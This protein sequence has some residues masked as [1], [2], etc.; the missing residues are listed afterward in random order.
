M[1][2]NKNNLTVSTM[3]ECDWNME[4]NKENSIILVNKFEPGSHDDDEPRFE[5]IWVVSQDSGCIEMMS[6]RLWEREHEA[7]EPC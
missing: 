3:G 2:P 1:V 7:A 5:W 4:A 6:V